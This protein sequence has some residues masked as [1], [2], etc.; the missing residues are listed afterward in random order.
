LPIITAESFPSFRGQQLHGIRFIANSP[1]DMSSSTTPK[2]LRLVIGC[3]EAGVDLKNIILKDLKANSGVE[4][5][6][7]ASSDFLGETSS[8]VGAHT[9]IRLT[10]LLLQISAFPLRPTNERTVT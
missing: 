8:R 7:G 5:V 4:S 2:A 1:K 6:E 9:H 10:C 3:D